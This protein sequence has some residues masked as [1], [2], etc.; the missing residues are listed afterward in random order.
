MFKRKDAAALE[1]ALDTLG[2]EVRYNIRTARNEYRE[3]SSVWT[4]FNERA[5]AE[6][7]ARIA[8][9]RSTTSEQTGSRRHS[10]SAG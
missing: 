9:T 4:P 7:R 10:T 2:L 5:A 6:I 3:Q 1:A 8:L